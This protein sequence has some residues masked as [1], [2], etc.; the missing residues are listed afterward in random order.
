MPPSVAAR[1]EAPVHHRAPVRPARPV[2]RA[3]PR[4]KRV[5]GG[6]VWIAL[7]GVLLVG[8]V[9]V[10]V[11]A[12]RIK[13]QSDRLGRERVSLLGK[14]AQLSSRLSTAAATQRIQDLAHT[15]LGLVPAKP[16]ETIY[17]RLHR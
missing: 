7:V 8:V 13:V 1:V 3:R 6:V 10:N 15:K 17:L 4:Q 9:A 16:D 11:A 5:T 14:K 12:L 2:R